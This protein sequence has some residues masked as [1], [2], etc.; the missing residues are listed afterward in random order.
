MTREEYMAKT[1]IKSIEEAEKL[2]T[3]FRTINLCGAII[4]V[5]LSLD[6]FM[7]LPIE[8]FY[9]LIGLFIALGAYAS[10]YYSKVGRA[11]NYARIVK[12]PKYFYF[13]GA[14]RSGRDYFA[15]TKALKIITGK[16]NPPTGSAEEALNGTINGPETVTFDKTFGKNL[17]WATLIAIL[18][19]IIIIIAIEKGL[20]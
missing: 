19:F 16:I 12:M 8:Y 5:L 18:V 13:N 20:L 7:S 9:I 3:G 10:F 4:A 14:N 17:L 11:L 15:L 6:L 2:L 1:N